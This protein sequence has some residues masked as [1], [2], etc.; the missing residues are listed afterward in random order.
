[1][2]VQGLEEGGGLGT[3]GCGD[4][5]APGLG[6]G[7]DPTLEGGGLVAW[8]LEH[9]CIMCFTQWSCSGC[10]PQFSLAGW[11]WWR[12]I[13]LGLPSPILSRDP[14]FQETIKTQG[15]RRFLKRTMVAKNNREST[16][17]ILAPLLLNH[18]PLTS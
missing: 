11:A 10:S 13:I 14:S 17:L 4:L 12:S 1:M 15:N 18:E 3:V 9:I 6:G 16:T 5:C 2:Q 7:G 8:G